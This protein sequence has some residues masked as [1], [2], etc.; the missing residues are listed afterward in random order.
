M[1]YD[2][3]ILTLPIDTAA[4]T[5]VCLEELCSVPYSQVISPNPSS[6]F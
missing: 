6:A 5:Y 3:L 1:S 2:P 4:N